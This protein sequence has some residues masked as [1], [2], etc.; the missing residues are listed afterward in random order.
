MRKEPMCHENHDRKG[1]ELPYRTSREKGDDTENA[2]VRHN[3]E[4]I[5]GTSTTQSFSDAL[6]DWKRDGRARDCIHEI[7]HVLSANKDDND[8]EKAPV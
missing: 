2:V 4:G 3:F 5:R 8:R 7:E 6:L 1:A